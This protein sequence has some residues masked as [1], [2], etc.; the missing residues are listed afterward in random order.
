MSPDALALALVG[1]VLA[2]F[3][4]LFGWMGFSLLRFR[5]YYRH[6]GEVAPEMPL[7]ALV[8][9]V[10]REGF[11]M[12]TLGWWQLRA[13]GRDGLL[14][15][16]GP[17]TGPPVLCV[18]GI[19]QAGSNLWGIRRA[20]ARRGR[21]SLAVSLGRFRLR[22]EDHVPPLV[23]ALRALIARSPDGR[24]DVVA[25]SMGGVVLRLALAVH[26]ELAPGIRRVVTLGS[27]HAG[28]AASRGLPLGGTV[29]ALGRRSAV[30]RGLPPFPSGTTLTTIAARH[31]LVVYPQATCHLDGARTIDL[32]D[33]GHAGLLTIPAVQALVVEAL[34]GEEMPDT[35]ER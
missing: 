9:Y 20:L 5:A 33:V 24:V 4:G 18:H 10:L 2:G 14:P 34:C 19:T 35:A 1:G 22:I 29:R 11:A 30:L 23:T 27:P 12:L 3:V 28:T 16:E 8:R 26:P 21:A 7:G 31:D 13:A 6:K 15:A 32:P 17:E 25:H